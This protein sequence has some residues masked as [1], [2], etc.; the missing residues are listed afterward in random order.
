MPV[1]GPPHRCVGR[2]LVDQWINGFGFLGSVVFFF[3]YERCLKEEVGMAKVGCVLWFS[4][5]RCCWVLLVVKDHQCL[6]SMLLGF[7]VAQISDGFGGDQCGSWRGH[8]WWRWGWI[9]MS[10]AMFLGFYCD[11][12]FLLVSLVLLGFCYD[13]GFFIFYF[14]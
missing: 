14:F 6:G 12:G 10:F 2:G 13:I 1:V 5:V 11:A 7:W 3:G 4:Q 8:A 9:P